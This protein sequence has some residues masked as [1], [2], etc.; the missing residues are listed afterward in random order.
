[1]LSGAVVGRYHRSDPARARL[2]D[3]AAR[4]RAL[5]KIPDSHRIVILP[6]SDTG[7]VEAAMWNLLG[8]RGVEILAF[9]FFG[10]EWARDVTRELKLPDARVHEAPYGEMPDLARVDFARDVVFAWT[11]TTAGTSVP[12]GGWIAKDRAGL[13]ICDATAAAFAAELPWELLDAASF[14]WQKAMGGEAQHG[15]LVLGPR[16][17]A[18]IRDYRPPW[19]MPKLFR[20]AADGRLDEGLFDGGAVNTPSLLAVEDALY[21]LEWIEREGGLAGMIAR[22]QVNRAILDDWIGASGWA[23]HLA[24]DAG[25]RA[26]TPVTMRFSGAA[27][28]LPEPEQRGLGLAMAAALEREGVA[29]DVAS[30]R[31][32][33]PGL[34]VWTGGTIMAE[35]LAA[36][37]PWLDWA[38]KEAYP[39]A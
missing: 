32:A 13:T 39:G 20:I 27:G 21:A 31:A 18:R 34:R 25:I 3:V 28:A 22:T 19:P 38:F 14:S 35:D 17:V 29:Y 5:L 8:A 23:A 11:G 15:M 26:P 12:G 9:D 2:R 37:C 30:Y 36:L 33:P 4:S 7:A 6:G 16:A 24:R 1:M 10:R